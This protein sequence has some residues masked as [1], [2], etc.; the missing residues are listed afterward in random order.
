MFTF[1]SFVCTQRCKINKQC[2]QTLL[3][4]ISSLLA[5]YLADQYEDSLKRQ[6]NK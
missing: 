5:N 4:P 2:Q 3:A 1:D 6:H